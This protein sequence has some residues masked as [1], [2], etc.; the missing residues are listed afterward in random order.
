M[1]YFFFFVASPFRDRLLDAPRIA[2]PKNSTSERPGGNRGR[3]RGYK[4]P[5]PPRGGKALRPKPAP[6]R[7]CPKPPNLAWRRETGGKGLMGDP[8]AG[9]QPGE[10]FLPP[11]LPPRPGRKVG[12]RHRGIG[13]G[14]NPV[15]ET[16]KTVRLEAESV[17][18]STRSR[19]SSPSA[20]L[21][22]AVR[23]FGG[24]GRKGQPRRTSASESPASESRA[25]RSIGRQCRH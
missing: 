24:R 11:D 5:T 4:P 13:R 8:C 19:F 22:W 2:S 23:V 20:E 21:R 7:P 9:R 16:R 6:G 3:R 18:G 1:L 15:Q 12:E 10:R 17:L 14:G 25:S